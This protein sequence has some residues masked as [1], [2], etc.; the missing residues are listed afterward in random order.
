MMPPFAAGGCSPV[1][2]A[3]MAEHL[4]VSLACRPGTLRLVALACRP[5][6]LRLAA[7]APPN[8]RLLNMKCPMAGRNCQ[9]TDFAKRPFMSPTERREATVTAID[10]P[11]SA[12]PLIADRLANVNRW[13]SEVGLGPLAADD[14]PKATE[15][16]Q[17]DDVQAMYVEAIPDASSTSEPNADTGTLAAMAAGD[18]VV[19]FFKIT[20]DA[21]ARRRPARPIQILP[22]VG[23]VYRPRQNPAM[24]TSELAKP[25]IVA[26][27]ATSA[28][29]LDSSR[30]TADHA[31]SVLASLRLTVVLFA[32]SI[33]L[34]FVGTLAQVDH[35]VWD[36]VNHAY[37][38][39]WFARVDFQA[40]ERLVQMF[41]PVEWNL[42]G[43]FFFPGGKLIGGMLLVNLF[44]AHVVR[45]KVAAD[46]WRLRGG[47]AVVALGVLVTALVI[48]SGM[49][50]TLGSELSP[51]FCNGLWFALRTALSG[52]ALAGGYILVLS[53]DRRRGEW[54][55][56]AGDRDPVGRASGLAVYSS[57]RPP[58][59][60]RIAYSVATG[61]R[62]GRRRHLAGRLH[63][64][65][66]QA[67]R[68]CA[69]ARRRGAA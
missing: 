58:R 33:F 50:D 34:V 63:H 25:D 39:V 19:W 42:R 45:F 44:A 7:L 21:Q 2:P 15:T 57:R 41:Y 48:R 59:R 60:L 30:F 1:P 31:L 54:Y 68:R 9:P 27:N 65:V 61:Q 28:G 3:T 55:L 12:G 35:G 13:R 62:S 18:D 56:L 20:G 69:P 51:A 52:L 38:R 40:F 10:F 8:Q 23:Q 6:I 4:R 22:Q 17:V 64:G 43:G 47:L 46:G 29:L 32:M 11:A 5:G 24:A 26:P 53:F 14:L 66:P 67:G 36:V 16:I 37:F 49:N